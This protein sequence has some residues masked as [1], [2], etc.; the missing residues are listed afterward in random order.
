MK[1][2][3]TDCVKRGLHVKCS[4]G[5]FLHIMFWCVGFVAGRLQHESTIPLS[6]LANTKMLLVLACRYCR[7]QLKD[8]FLHDGAAC[9]V[10]LCLLGGGA[11]SGQSQ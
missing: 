3:A 4:E 1:L 10:L 9:S 8:K 7:A 6:D 5:K 11:V 2:H